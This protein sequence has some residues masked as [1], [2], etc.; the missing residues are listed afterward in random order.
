MTK[1]ARLVPCQFLE[2]LMSHTLTDRH[3]RYRDEAF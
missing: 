1:E 2:R 3:V